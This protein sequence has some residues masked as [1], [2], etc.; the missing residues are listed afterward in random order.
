MERP[1]ATIMMFFPFLLDIFVIDISN[2][3]PFHGFPSEN[4]LSHLPFPCSPTHPMLLLCP[5]ILLH[6]GIEPSQ[7]QGPLLPSMSDKAIICYICS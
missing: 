5:G 1:T 4:L 6:W 3:I 7:D 2:V